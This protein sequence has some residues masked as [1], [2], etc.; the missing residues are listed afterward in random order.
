[1]WRSYINSTVRNLAVVVV[2]DVGMLNRPVHT[3]MYREIWSFAY[4]PY[5]IATFEKV[6]QKM[7]M[8]PHS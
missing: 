8:L 6:W 5:K 7:N 3:V 1:M 2:H 4:F